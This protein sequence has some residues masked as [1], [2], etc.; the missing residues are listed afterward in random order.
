MKLVIAIVSEDDA[1][2]IMDRLRDARFSVTKLSS[3][4]GF[5]RLGNTTLLSGIDDD[6]VQEFISIVENESK[7]HTQ[8]APMVSGFFDAIHPSAEVT[9]S[10]A[11]IF[12]LDVEQFIKV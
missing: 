12:I 11:T 1:T 10:G 6:K 7:S 9:I 4:G 5:L 2:L 8:P 3:S